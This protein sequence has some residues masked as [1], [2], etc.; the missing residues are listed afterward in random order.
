ME[1]AYELFQR[2]N[3]LIQ[4]E[5][6]MKKNYDL[7]NLE[8]KSGKIKVDKEASRIMI[9]LK[10]DANNLADVKTEAE[11][12]GMPYQTLLNS[13]IHRYIHGELIDKKDL[14]RLA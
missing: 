14:K 3:L 8:K 11:R 2:E 5:R 6:I 4:K 10:M 12:L 9:S 7:K 13:I 1:I